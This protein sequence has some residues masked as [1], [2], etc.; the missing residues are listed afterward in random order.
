M[1]LTISKKR[2]YEVI[3]N[4][5]KFEK[6]SHAYLIEVDNYDQDFNCILDFVKLILCS[7]NSIDN[8]SELVDKGN[9]PDLKIIE[10]DGNV[11]KK[12]QLIQLQEEFKNKSFLNNRM[13]YVL[14]EADKLNDSSGNTIL[15]LLEEPEDDIIAILVTTNRYKV[16]ETIL[17]RCQV[18][19]LKDN[20]IPLD[21]SDT[22]ISLIDFI[23]KK[24]DLFINYQYIID[25]I[26]PEKNVAKKVLGEVEVVFINY[27][28]YL[29]NMDN[30][31]INQELI[32]LFKNVSIEQIINFIA[33]IEEEIQKLEFNINYKLW[34]DG[35]FARLIG[36]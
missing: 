36:G 18:L 11:I 34:L 21:I 25:D 17:S 7:K 10:P 14:K 28:N 33:I 16:I 3:N 19:S 27:L 9:Y 2:F 20:D 24:D 23:I 5:V 31:K 15:K 6:I 1:D 12:R 35:L 8:I 22:I 4:I 29:S 30:Y 26:L 13:I 32:K